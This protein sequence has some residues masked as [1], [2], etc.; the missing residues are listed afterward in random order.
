MFYGSNGWTGDEQVRLMPQA[1]G[2]ASL[3]LAAAVQAFEATETEVAAFLLADVNKDLVLDRKEFKTFVLEMAKTGHDTSKTVRA[4]GA[5]G[6]AF[7][8]TDQNK[9]GVV[10]PQELRTADEDFQASK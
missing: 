3:C 5:Y 7:R 10:T 2:V 4:F 8:I 6:Y 9:D 1:L